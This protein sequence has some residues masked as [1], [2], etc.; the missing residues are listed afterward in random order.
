M[1]FVVVI[2]EYVKGVILVIK[3]LS[4]LIVCLIIL[5]SNMPRTEAT[6]YY[7]ISMTSPINSSNLFYSDE[8][9]AISFPIPSN[10]IKRIPFYLYNKTSEP[11]KIDWNQIS[12]ISTNS[13]SLKTYHAG[14]L[15]ADANGNKPM[16]LGIIPPKTKLSDFIGISNG[17]HFS[18]GYIG[19]EEDF[20][21]P[22]WFKYAE[23]YKNNSFGIFLPLE[24]NG[25]TKYYTFTFLI[26][27][28][29][30]NWESQP[31]LGV[32][33][34]DKEMSIDNKF[35][36]KGVFISNI[37][38]KSPAEK[39]GIRTSDVMIN[40]NGSNID[41]YSDFITAIDKCNAGD[42]VKITVLR[43][44]QPFDIIVTLGERPKP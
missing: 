23:P 16:S 29:T 25:K 12:F 15:Y 27:K 13:S 40:F 35:N 7:S 28:V 18:G 5:F 19:W 36:S 30:K 41:T 31:Y 17:L 14:I 9:I 38:P 39:A 32:G 26:N 8:N 21:F 3:K 33:S 43:N 42:K 22:D 1:L 11:I 44:D 6:A 24:V 20:I 34:Y 37:Y 10:E 2:R 4:L